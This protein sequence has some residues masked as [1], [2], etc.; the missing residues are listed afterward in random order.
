LKQ[1]PVPPALFAL[2]SS[3]LSLTEGV[4]DSSAI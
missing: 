4:R 1:P 3:G 2:P